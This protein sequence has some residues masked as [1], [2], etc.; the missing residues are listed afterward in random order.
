[1]SNTVPA[2]NYRQ[3]IHHEGIFIG[4][5]LKTCPTKI[6]LG[7][8]VCSLYHVY[9]TFHSNVWHNTRRLYHS[10]CFY[11]QYKVL[12]L[13]DMFSKLQHCSMYKLGALHQQQ[14]DLVALRSLSW[15]VT[16]WCRTCLDSDW[17]LMDNRWKIVPPIKCIRKRLRFEILT[18][19][20]TLALKLG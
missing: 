7:P 9:S 12:I 2:F 13:Q 3:G 11:H 5:Q 15:P 18:V 10:S 4:G 19:I 16:C 17:L 20:F 14:L 6:P 1:M 8:V